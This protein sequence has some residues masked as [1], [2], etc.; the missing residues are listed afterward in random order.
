MPKSSPVNYEGKKPVIDIEK[1]RTYGEYGAAIESASHIGV[2][3]Y[4]DEAVSGRITD[5]FNTI[6][7]ELLHVIQLRNFGYVGDILTEGYAESY[8]WSIESL[9]P[10]KYAERIR[11]SE[12][13]DERVNIAAY[14]KNE[15]GLDVDY[16]INWLTEDNIKK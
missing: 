6:I 15:C 1:R 13:Q 14:G 16:D 11:Y 8:A 4:E 10:K 7:H 2:S 3:F 12:R 9:L 5:D